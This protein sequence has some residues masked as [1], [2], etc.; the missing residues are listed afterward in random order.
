LSKKSRTVVEYRRYDLPLEF[1]VLSL[2]GDR[3]HISD[4]R[5]EHL[6]FHNCLEIGICLSGSGTMIFDGEP[7]DF[8]GGDLTCIPR[9][10]PHTTYSSDGTKSLWSYLFVNLGQLFREVFHNST[11]NFDLEKAAFQNIPYIMN[12]DEYPRI[13]FLVLSIIEEMRHKKESYQASVIGLFLSLYVELNR[14]ESSGQANKYINTASKNSLIISPALNYIHQNYMHQFSI[15][16]LAELCHLSTTHFRRLFLSIMGTPPLNFI[17]TMR[18]D[19]ACTLLQ[20]T[21]KSILSIAESSGFHSISSF[22]RY[23]YKLMGVSPRDYRNPN[24]R[25]KSRPERKTILEYSGWL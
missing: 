5:S 25:P 17:N 19:E 23:F 14:L 21:D 13:Y 3:W 11:D 10:F 20:T 7:V 2:D 9:H 22:N 8:E 4:I 16:Y 18:I 15:E 24:N 6:H 1:P 12:K